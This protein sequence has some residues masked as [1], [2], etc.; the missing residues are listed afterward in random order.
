MPLPYLDDIV[1][2]RL[3]IRPVTE[4]NLDD[5]LSINGDDQVTKFLPYATWRS[6]DDGRAWL[7]RMNAIREAGTGQQLVMADNIGK[8]VGTVLLFRFEEGSQRI[9]IGY[10]VG[11]PHWRQGFAKEAL[12]AVC[13]Y[14]FR[15]LSIRRI[16]GEVDPLNHASNAVLQSLGFVKEGLLRKRWITKGSETD[17]NI[18]GCLAEEWMNKPA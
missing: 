9:E 1:T 6:L 7:K 18:Y 5:L 16:E 17:V 10:V 15:M 8:V 3:V 14:A 13:D 4:N 12:H 2:H 11:R